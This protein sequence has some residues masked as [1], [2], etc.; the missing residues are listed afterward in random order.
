MANKVD[1]WR[2][3]SILN[4]QDYSGRFWHAGLN[5]SGSLLL[6]VS[7][8]D[9]YSVV[10]IESSETIWGASEAD[11]QPCLQDLLVDGFAE[12]NTP[13]ISERFRV[14][15]PEFNHF[16]RY[17]AHD[18]FEFDDLNDV[19][20]VDTFVPNEKDRQKLEFAGDADEWLCASFSDE[21]SIIVIMNPGFVTIFGRA[22]EHPVT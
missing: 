3:I 17:Y 14:F 1:T 20:V 4:A 19:L 8:D 9:E 2:Q 11:S 6:L 5:N 18:H 12:I 16:L 22:T 13:D 7:I 21:G 15:G 10:D